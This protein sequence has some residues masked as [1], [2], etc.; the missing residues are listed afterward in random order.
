MSPGPQAATGFLGTVQSTPRRQNSLK[1]RVQVHFRLLCKKKKEKN[2][3]LN[4][5][6]LFYCVL[7]I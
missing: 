4:R 6:K 5:L 1:D 3:I 7:A 2:H